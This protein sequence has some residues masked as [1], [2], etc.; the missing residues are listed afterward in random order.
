MRWLWIGIMACGGEEAP[1]KERTASA[2]DEISLVEVEGCDG[3]VRLE[4]PADPWEKGPWPVGA[5]TA[6]VDGLTVE[7]WYPAEPGSAAGVPP[8]DYDIR[9]ALPPTQQSLIP[10]A[11]APSHVGD[12]H[13]DL[14]LDPRGPFPVVVF[15]HGTASWR[16]QSLSL[17][18]LWAS[19]GFVVVAADHPGLWL[20]DTL[21]LICPDQPS[22]P[23]DLEGDVDR[24]LDALSAPEG[25][26]AF[27]EGRL[28]TSRV[29]MTGHSAGGSVAALLVD[30]PGVEVVIP[31]ASGTP[32]VTS[33]TLKAT[34]FL[35]G[36]DDGVVPFSST[37]SGFDATSSPKWL[38]GLD[39]AG[40]L[41][42]SDICGISNDSGA[43]M[44]SI[45]VD[46]GVCGAAFAGLL[47]DCDSD[48]LEEETASRLVAHATMTVLETELACIDR[49][50]A[51]TSLEGDADIAVFEAV[52]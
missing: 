20:A 51:W 4:T 40:H 7:V 10:D 50:D 3:S 13:A 47:F 26:L 8:M 44:L 19:R 9:Y 34:L 48:F 39:R 33:E 49:S 32:P 42:F 43:D 24:I 25:D 35:G 41:A 1:K 46:A 30:R 2:S 45:A 27:L 37:Q 6:D 52:P 16:S 31:M 15:V 38:V 36:I 18:T 22:G 11:M 28:D 12:C 5:R 17:M 14:P 21:S 23:Q 29:A